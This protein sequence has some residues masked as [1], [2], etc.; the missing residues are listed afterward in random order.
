MYTEIPP[1]GIKKGPVWVCPGTKIKIYK[2]NGLFHARQSSKSKDRWQACNKSLSALKKLCIQRKTNIERDECWKNDITEAERDAIVAVRRLI[3]DR[4]L[5]SVVHEWKGFVEKHGLK[6]ITV[7]EAVE[8]FLAWKTTKWSAKTLNSRKP[9]LNKLTRA[10]GHKQFVDVF[11][12]GSLEKL[13]GELKGRSRNGDTANERPT[14]AAETKKDF[15]RVVDALIDFAKDHHWLP[16]D[17]THPTKYLDISG[18]VTPARYMTPQ[19]KDELILRCPFELLPMLL[20][21]IFT[22]IRPE[23]GRLKKVPNNE[24]DLAQSY[25]WSSLN[26]EDRT[27]TAFFHETK[28]KRPKVVKMPPILYDCLVFFEGLEGFNGPIDPPESQRLL[29]HYAYDPYGKSFVRNAL[30]HAV[31]TNRFA[32]P[33]DKESTILY[34]T[35]TSLEE[36]NRRY[37]E[38]SKSRPNDYKKWKSL[39]IPEGHVWQRITKTKGYRP[40]WWAFI[41]PEIETAFSAHMQE[42]SRKYAKSTQCDSTAFHPTSESSFAS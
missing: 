31:L 20:I 14:A 8:R 6:P 26:Y 16:K 32:D 39:I 9:Y 3:G 17:I 1:C 25:T 15:K 24:Y 35:Q 27:I 37:R 34:E 12:D 23:E 28:L 38:M 13:V 5:L 40:E 21:K 22:G 19:E 29:K 4:D 7:F 42:V 33:K 36:F 11:T 2:S 10:F 41:T 18:P 30:R